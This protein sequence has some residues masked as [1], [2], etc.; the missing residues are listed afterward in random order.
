MH[1]LEGTATAVNVACKS[2]VEMSLD[3]AFEEVRLLKSRISTLATRL[4]PASQ[5]PTPCDSASA[6]E[7][8]PSSPLTGSILSIAAGVKEATLQLEEIT[9]LLDL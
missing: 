3:Q 1:K 9:N 2:N 5:T 8:L 6:N 7:F 4:I